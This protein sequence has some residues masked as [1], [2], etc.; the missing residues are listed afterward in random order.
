[1]IV[2]EN[3]PEAVQP[4][5]GNVFATDEQSLSSTGQASLTKKTV[6]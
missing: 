1:M 3:S 4:F 5:C 6:L 2:Q